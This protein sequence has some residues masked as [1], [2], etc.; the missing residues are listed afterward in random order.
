MDKDRTTLKQQM[1]QP[2]AALAGLCLSSGVT[3]TVDDQAKC[4]LAMALGGRPKKRLD[5]PRGPGL[6]IAL[7]SK[8][9]IWFLSLF[10]TKS[11]DK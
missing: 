9:Y 7:L 2:V 1:G 6:R 11:Y 4:M 8:N 3:F 10:R 5:P